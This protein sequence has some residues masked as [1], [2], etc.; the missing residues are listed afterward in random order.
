LCWVFFLAAVA[1]VLACG[2]SAHTDVW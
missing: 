2:L 1:G